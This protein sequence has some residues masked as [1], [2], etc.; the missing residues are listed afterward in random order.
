VVLVDVCQDLVVTDVDC[1]TQNGVHRKALVQGGD[2]VIPLRDRILGRTT[3]VD[4]ISNIDESVV[5]PAGEM[6]DEKYFDA[7]EANNV[8]EVLV[9]SAVTCETRYGITICS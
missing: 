7:I 6:I 8:D 3:A 2:V 5:V 9:R 1:G 4:V